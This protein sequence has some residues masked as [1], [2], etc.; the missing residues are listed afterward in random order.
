MCPG[1]AERVLSK[2]GG[3]ELMRAAMSMTW[4]LS[5]SIARYQISHFV[6]RKIFGS[7]L[8]EPTSY[9]LCNSRTGTV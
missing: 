6:T 4:T 7:T 2:L 5:V 3:F 1:V 8:Y 9:I